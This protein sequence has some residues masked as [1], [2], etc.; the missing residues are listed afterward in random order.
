MTQKDHFTP[1]LK[2]IETMRK[3][4]IKKLPT[5]KNYKNFGQAEYQ[6]FRAMVNLNSNLSY[7]E[8]ADLCSRFADMISEIQ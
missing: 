6:E 1:Y 4:L 3:R 2:G 8:R 5:H 7:S